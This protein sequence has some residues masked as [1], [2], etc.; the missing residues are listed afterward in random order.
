MT[1]PNTKI[2]TLLEALEEMMVSVAMSVRDAPTSI[3]HRPGTPFERLL[4]ARTEAKRALQEYIQPT[5][6]VVRNVPNI[7]NAENLEIRHLSAEL[8]QLRAT[9]PNS[10]PDGVR[11]PDEKFVFD[12][13]NGASPT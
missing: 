10:K 13:P 9:S 11:L 7:P 8:R 4:Q 2:E 3:A 1:A 5:F 6:R 12:W